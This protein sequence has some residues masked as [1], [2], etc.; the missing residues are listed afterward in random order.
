MK[1]VRIRTSGIEAALARFDHWWNARSPRERLLLGVLA[2]LLGGVVLVY[3]VIRP[4]QAARAEAVADIRTYETLS[5]RIR[6]AGTL[7]ATPRPQR[8]G[9]PAEAVRE[10]AAA[11]GLDALIEPAGNGVRATVAEGSYDSVLGWIADV[12]GTTRLRVTRVSIARRPA[13]GRVAATV[14][15][16]S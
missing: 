13:S 3:G 4:L 1:I 8:R 12:G 9:A 15:F 11:F 16:A 7:S 14:D 10:S 5:A 2:V 6:A